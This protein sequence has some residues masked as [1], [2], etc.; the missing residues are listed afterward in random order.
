MPS[1]SGLSAR[2]PASGV[3]PP[4]P[5][6]GLIINFSTNG[7]IT[8]VRAAS[9]SI[10]S[11]III[12]TYRRYVTPGTSFFC[13]TCNVRSHT[14]FPRC[15]YILYIQCWTCDAQ[16]SV[17]LG[18]RCWQCRKIW[19]G[20]DVMLWRLDAYGDNSEVDMEALM[21]RWKAWN[22]EVLRKG[23][24]G[25]DA[26]YIDVGGLGGRGDDGRGPC[27]WCGQRVCRT[28]PLRRRRLSRRWT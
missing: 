23:E 15:R 12:N 1:T 10:C 22:T 13:S 4:P 28:C 27:A 3:C 18:D 26:P 21:M 20:C 14:R 9:C 2:C 17:N 11:A 25:V 8:T 6:P 5:P 16:S 7:T 24:R 19:D